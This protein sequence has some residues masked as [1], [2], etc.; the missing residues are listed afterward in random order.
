MRFGAA[1]GVILGAIVASQA[2]SAAESDGSLAI[3]LAQG[4]SLR[5]VALA[6]TGSL[7]LGDRSRV[8]PRFVRVGTVSERAAPGNHCSGVS[9]NVGSNVLS[10]GQVALSNNARIAGS[11][12]TVNAPTTQPGAGVTLG[13]TLH[14]QLTPVSRL[15]WL[16]PA[17]GSQAAYTLNPDQTGTRA[18]SPR[19]HSPIMTGSR[20]KP[21]FELDE[22]S[23]LVSLDLSEGT[24][25]KP[26]CGAA[27]PYLAS[28]AR[29]TSS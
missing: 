17:P 23:G 29:P 8:V 10:V 28:R 11:L 1:I 7:Q 22:Q 21:K 18:A 20:R 26:R 4:V 24:R 14:A 19:R 3:R 9:S 27:V 6:A 25:A 2:T 13:T 16:P 5:N 12:L 15:A